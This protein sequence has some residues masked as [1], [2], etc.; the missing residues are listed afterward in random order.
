MKGTS[1]VYVGPRATFDTASRSAGVWAGLVEP[2]AGIVMST[3]E[4]NPKS[5]R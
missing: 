1:H 4:L 2:G 3:V 5:P